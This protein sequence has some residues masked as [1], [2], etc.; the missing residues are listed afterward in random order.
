MSTTHYSPS[1]SA[2]DTERYVRGKDNSRGV[3]ITCDVPGP[4]GT[5]AARARALT[6]NTR[7]EVEVLHYRQSFGED[8]D[9]KDPNHVQRANDLGYLL[10]K[11]MHPHAD[12]LVVTHTDGRGGKVHNHILVINHDDS[13]G[14][15]LSDYRTF[16]DRKAGNQHGVQSANDE[17]MAEHGLSVV[18]RIE[19]QPKDWELRREDFAEG[20]L[21]RQMGDRMTAALEDP[22][23]TSKAALIAVLDEQNQLPGDDGRA[24]PRMRL[25]T[26]IAKKGKRQGL[27]TW[28]LYIEDQRGETGRA[29]RRKR[30]SVLSADFTPEG[31]QAFFDYHQQ[32]HIQK[33]QDNERSARTDEAARR[34]ASAA[35]HAASAACGAGGQDDGDI[36]LDPHRRR[37]T[38]QPSRRIGAAAAEARLVREGHGRGDEQADRGHGA[39]APAID[40]AGIR[41][42]TRRLLD[43]REHEERAARD[44]ADAEL[45]RQRARREADRRRSFIADVREDTDREDDGMEL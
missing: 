23:S 43:E 27:E 36:D 29:E 19:H 39:A 16:H 17:L 28:T 10:G 37:N 30:T 41:A 40:H 22:R 9:P 35:R 18:K 45:A 11:K 14:K 2:A 3:A 15:A 33:E 38:E 24:V 32:N 12:V 25:H 6:Q 1:N 42:R 5:F 26:S 20:S 8:F 44:R 7:R 34:A 13:T 4:P 31:T 21:D